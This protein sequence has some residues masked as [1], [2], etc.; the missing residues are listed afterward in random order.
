MNNVKYILFCGAFSS[1]S[2]FLIGS[3]SGNKS[4]LSGEERYAVDTLYSNRVSLYRSEADSL[5]KI[6][7]GVNYGRI[8]DSIKNETLKE[9]ELLLNKKIFA[10]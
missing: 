10:E 7:N 2:I 4:E 9:I 6:Y 3:C 1:L 5:C 8:R